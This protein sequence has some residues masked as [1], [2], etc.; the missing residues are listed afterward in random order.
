MGMAESRLMTGRADDAL[1]RALAYAQ[2]VTGEVYGESPDITVLSYAGLTIDDVRELRALVSSGPVRAPVRVIIIRAERFYAE[3]QNAFLKMIE[4][5]VDSVCL[6]LSVPSEAT[7][8]PTVLSRLVRDIHEESGQRQL[9]QSTQTFLQLSRK[10]R[11][12]YAEKLSDRAKSG[13]EE[14]KRAVRASIRELV[15]EITLAVRHRKLQQSDNEREMLLKELSLLLPV[16]SERSAPVKMV[17][18][19]LASVIPEPV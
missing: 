18:L 5:P 9:D 4:E 12:M 19:H 6:I 16:L 10:E 2:S 3:A 17:L 7:L 11:A 1:A 14:D 15:E 13:S 8:L